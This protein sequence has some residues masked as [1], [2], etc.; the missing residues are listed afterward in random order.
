MIKLWFK[1]IGQYLDV[2][3]TVMVRIFPLMHPV[4]AAGRGLEC[5]DDA[6][7]YAYLG[8]T[9]LDRLGSRD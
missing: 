5:P 3:I 6:Q 1:D 4:L 7:G 9:M 2:V 8:A